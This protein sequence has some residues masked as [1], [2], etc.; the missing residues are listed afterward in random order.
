MLF[1]AKDASSQ[2]IMLNR[3][4]NLTRLSKHM[5]SSNRMRRVIVSAI[6]TLAARC[7]NRC[8]S[9]GDETAARLCDAANSFRA[10][11]ERAVFSALPEFACKALEKEFAL[12]EDK[13]ADI[14]W[15]PLADL[16]FRRGESCLYDLIVYNYE[17]QA[18]A[19][20]LKV[21]D[22]TAKEIVEAVLAALKG[23]S[24]VLP[25]PSPNKE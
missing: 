10:K 6:K 25:F 8:M 17:G 19:H 7:E 15:P 20:F 18:S 24:N 16:V 14:S 12:L 4:N 1:R 11:F 2:R 13:P 3:F 9:V 23:G 21:V 5:N 22:A